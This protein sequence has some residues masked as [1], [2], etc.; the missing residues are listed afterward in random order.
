[1]GLS[2]VPDL[3]ETHKSPQNGWARDRFKIGVRNCIA[4]EIGD[5]MTKKCLF[6]ILLFCFFMPGCSIMLAQ[7]G[8]PL[9]EPNRDAVC[10]AFGKP[11]ES[12]KTETGSYGEFVSRKKYADPVAASVYGKSYGMTFGVLA[13]FEPIAFT[14]EIAK[15]VK[16]KSIGRRVRFE[17]DFDG[18]VIGRETAGSEALGIPATD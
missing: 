12:G 18:N 7:Y 5:S 13:V 15:Y 14:L 9:P 4:S 3:F 17:F 8:D 2:L 6:T 11:I 10:A 1:M 16:A